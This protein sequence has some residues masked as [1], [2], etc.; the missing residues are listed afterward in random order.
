VGC[1]CEY[2]LDSGNQ[3]LSIAP[4]AGMTYLKSIPPGQL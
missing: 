2:A 3:T 1:L 4:E